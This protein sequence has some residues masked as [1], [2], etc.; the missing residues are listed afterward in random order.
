MIKPE[1]VSYC[2]EFITRMVGYYRSLGVDNPEQKAYL[3]FVLPDG[4][5]FYRFMELAGRKNWSAPENRQ[6]LKSE[7]LSIFELDS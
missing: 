5:H 7:L 3:L 2:D 1:I 6:E 4:L